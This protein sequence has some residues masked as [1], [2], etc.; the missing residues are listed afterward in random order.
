MRRNCGGVWDYCFLLLTVG[1]YTELIRTF[2]THFWARW[3]IFAW[4]AWADHQDSAIIIRRFWGYSVSI[5]AYQVIACFIVANPV[6]FSLRFKE[7]GESA[8]HLRFRE[9]MSR[10]RPSARR[11]ARRPMPLLTTFTRTTL[12]RRTRPLRKCV[13]P[14]DGSWRSVITT[15][16]A[17]LGIEFSSLLILLARVLRVSS[18]TRPDLRRCCSPSRVTPTHPVLLATKW[19]IVWEKLCIWYIYFT[20][21]R[22]EYFL[23]DELLMKILYCKF[24][25]QKVRYF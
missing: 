3:A 6:F 4:S 13:R 14:R 9:E 12:P 5:A 23:L 17:P 21:K 8:R 11:L 7:S 24:F 2:W 19:M 15:L 10:A 18:A 25:L 20:V 16:L 22:N 1:I